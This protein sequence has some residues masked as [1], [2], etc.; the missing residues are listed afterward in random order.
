MKKR[1]FMVLFA[2]GMIAITLLTGCSDS[3]SISVDTPKWNI[4]V[5]T[6]ITHPTHTEAFHNE[7]YGLT[8]GYGGETH[9]TNDAGKEWPKSDIK[10]MCRYCIDIVDENLAWS[11]GNGDGV[12]YTNDGGR[13]W[14]EAGKVKLGGTHIHIDFIDNNVGWI[15]TYKKCASTKDGGNTWTEL[16]LP[17]EIEGISAIFLRTAEHAYLLS[18][19]GWLFTTSDGGT[20]WDKQNLEFENYEVK[21]EKGNPGLFK[22]NVAIADINFTDDNNGIIV[23][24]GIAPG[25]GSIAW[26][27]TTDDAGDTWVSEKIVPKEGFSANKVYLSSDGKY[28]TLGNFKK[29]LIV[30]KRTEM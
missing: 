27:L 6:K 11:G 2:V 29:E 14:N 5:D 25:Q 18:N 22:N 16:A 20:T 23:F 30:M 10:A 13:T 28:L 17:E 21:D 3:Q 8:V 12:F 15:A 4:V 26:C 24:A 7:N 19:D 1:L 9:Y